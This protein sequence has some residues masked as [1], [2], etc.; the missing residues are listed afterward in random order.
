MKVSELVK[1]ETRLDCEPLFQKYSGHFFDSDSK[2]FFASRISDAFRIP[3]VEG[4]VFL[5]S[6]KKCFQDSTRVWTIRK[7]HQTEYGIT[8]STIGEFGEYATK[9][10]ARSAIARELCQ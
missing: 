6:E 3:S 8:V 1:Y 7:L 2:R 5:T 10:Q 9:A 4:I